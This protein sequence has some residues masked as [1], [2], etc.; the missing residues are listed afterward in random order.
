MLLLSFYN[1]YICF[2][3]IQQGPEF[4]SPTLFY[5]EPFLVV[6]AS[7]VEP[8]TIAIINRSNNK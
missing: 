1:F 4:S 6:V 2:I 5:K 3:S 7:Q 8:L